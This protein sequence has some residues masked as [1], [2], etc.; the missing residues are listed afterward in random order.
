VVQDAVASPGAAHQAG[1]DRM[2]ALG[3]E[4]LTVKGLFYEWT[5]TVARAD[6]FLAARADLPAPSGSVL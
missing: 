5:R 2:R 6:A 1:L 3:V 4:L